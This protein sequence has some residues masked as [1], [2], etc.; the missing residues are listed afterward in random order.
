VHS[1][2]G[3]TSAELLTSRSCPHTT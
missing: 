2:F 3:I 1:D